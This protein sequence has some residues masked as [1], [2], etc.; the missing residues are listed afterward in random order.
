MCKGFAGTRA[1][2]VRSEGYVNPEGV[3]RLAEPIEQPAQT[4]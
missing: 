3:N 1:M 4:R 2:I